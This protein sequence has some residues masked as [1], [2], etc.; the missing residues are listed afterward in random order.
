MSREIKFRSW[1]VQKKVMFSPAGIYWNSIATAYF[2]KPDD[3]KYI[4]LN[5]QHLNEN[6]FILMQYTGLKDKN[7]VDL[8]WWEDDILED[9]NGY[10]FQIKYLDDSMRFGLLCLADLPIENYYFIQWDYQIEDLKKIGNIHE[11]PDL[12]KDLF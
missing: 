2:H 6:D 7:G 1:D 11:N 9:D 3:E 5:A 4:Y 8:D 12:L 10:K